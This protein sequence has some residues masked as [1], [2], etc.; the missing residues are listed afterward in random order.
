MGC[1]QEKAASKHRDF[2]CQFGDHTTALNVWRQYVAVK[3][4]ARRQWCRRH[5]VNSRAMA[6]AADI[7]QQVQVGHTSTVLASAPR[8]S[9]VDWH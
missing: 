1:R 4:K 9:L 8:D 7:F 6:N 2:H 5:F 3:P